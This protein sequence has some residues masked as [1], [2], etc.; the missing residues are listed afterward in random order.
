MNHDEL[1]ERLAAERAKGPAI[2]RWLRKKGLFGYNLWYWVTHPH[3]LPVV[4]VRHTRLKVVRFWQR[5]RRGWGDADTWS[6]DC[7]ILSWLP[8]AIDH[9]ADTSMGYDPRY[10]DCPDQFD[11]QRST[12]HFEAYVA[13]LHDIAEKLRQARPFPVR[14]DVLSNAEF[15]RTWKKLGKVFFHLWTE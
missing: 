5:G 13:D 3:R 12:E 1:L 9:V 8:D 11:C 7:Y 2:R 10:C 14:D 6:L 15:R 4:A